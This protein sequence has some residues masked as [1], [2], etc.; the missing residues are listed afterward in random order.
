[1]GDHTH[2]M[3][4]HGNGVFKLHSSNLGKNNGFNIYNCLILTTFCWV[5]VFSDKNFNGVQYG[6]L[7]SEQ[8]FHVEYWIIGQISN[9]KIY[10]FWLQK[11]V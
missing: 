7:V 9:N 4:D 1:M 6:L 2:T 3:G 8:F 5:F 10:Y 11:Y